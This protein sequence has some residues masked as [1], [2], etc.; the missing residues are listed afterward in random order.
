MSSLRSKK[1]RT[2]YLFCFFKPI[3][4]QTLNYN[5]LYRYCYKNAFH[6]YSKFEKDILN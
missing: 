1:I 6:I 2:Y 5:K 4:K 3:I